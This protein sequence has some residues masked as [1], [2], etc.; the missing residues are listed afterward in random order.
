MELRESLN[1]EEQEIV[2]PNIKSTIALV[3]GIAVIIGIIAFG[4]YIRKLFKSI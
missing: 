2:K 3:V 4:I 1:T